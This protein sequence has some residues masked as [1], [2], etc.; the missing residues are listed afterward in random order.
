M[1]SKLHILG[2]GAMY[3][4]F[5]QGQVGGSQ[6]IFNESTL[7]CFS[8]LAL[9]YLHWLLAGRFAVLNMAYMLSPNNFCLML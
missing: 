5:T 8:L 1:D 7:K 3:D 6:R 4:V 2:K 9:V